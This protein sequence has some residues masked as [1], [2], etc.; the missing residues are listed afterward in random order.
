MAA[1]DATAK[2]IL[3]IQGKEKN[4]KKTNESFTTMF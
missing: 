2:T 1:F 3:R 4:Q